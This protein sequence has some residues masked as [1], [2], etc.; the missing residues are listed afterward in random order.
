MSLL[1]Q[2]RDATCPYANICE[3]CDNFMPAPEF[4]PVL[5]AQLDDVRTLRDDADSRGW[6]DE[7][8]GHECVATTLKEHLQRL[9]T[10]G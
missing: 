6:T 5:K 9:G 10:T 1:H 3:Q 8:V 4:A 2:P 7:T